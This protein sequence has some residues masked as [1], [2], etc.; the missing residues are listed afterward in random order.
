MDQTNELNQKKSNMNN[1]TSLHDILS[2]EYLF[3]NWNK[4]LILAGIISLILG[5]IIFI[6]KIDTS[7]ILDNF[8]PI[9]IQ[10]V[11]ALTGI[12][13]AS[14]IFLLPKLS[15]EDLLAPDQF[16]MTLSGEACI[17]C[18]FVALIGGITITMNTCLYI[19]KIYNIF[20]IYWTISL[21]SISFFLFFLSVF[22]C[23]LLFMIILV[24]TYCI[25]MFEQMDADKQTDVER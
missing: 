7:I 20:N 13:M 16:N 4:P 23:I 9:S 3:S 14:M 10:V 22:G 2:R 5:I 24:H 11:S 17:H 21:A 18:F 25:S 1:H 12:S 15:G 8:L 6:Y 19:L